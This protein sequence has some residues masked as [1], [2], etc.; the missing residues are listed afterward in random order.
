MPRN[1]L[2][3]Q[4]HPDPAGGHFG[5]ALAAAYA[6]G[7]RVAGHTV[8]E[9][10]VARL[11][12]TF[13][14]T[15][16]D[17]GREPPPPALREAQDSIVWANHI[18][19]IYPLWL[20]SMPAILKAFLEQVMRP[21]LQGP[22]DKARGVFARP[23]KGR[24]AHVVITMGMPAFAYR[25]FF[26]AHS[27]KSLERNILKFMGIKPVRESLIGMVDGDAKRRARWLARLRRLGAEAA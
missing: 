3:V 1:I 2:L 26:G 25:W 23:L 16:E 10:A 13:L 8:R 5:H 24:T 18:V 22:D 9:I 4:G 6:E 27:L 21:N 7:A 14:R 19:L 17:W 20:G 11:D 12:F 15:K